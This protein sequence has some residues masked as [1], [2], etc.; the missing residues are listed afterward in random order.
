MK[1]TGVPI[2]TLLLKYDALQCS[3][4]KANYSVGRSVCVSWR[5]SFIF[6]FVLPLWESM[7]RN[8]RCV[9]MLLQLTLSGCLQHST[10]S[11]LSS[12][13]RFSFPSISL[14]LQS[15][16]KSRMAPL[17]CVPSC[18]VIELADRKS[19]VRLKLGSNTCLFLA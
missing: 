5:R 4:H 11:L 1:S 2:S 18:D 14:V 6:V 15:E 16:V 12:V 13:F 9:R 10:V 7:Y 17:K 19:R 3:E 8:V